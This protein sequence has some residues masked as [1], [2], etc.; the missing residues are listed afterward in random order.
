VS[1]PAATLERAPGAG[2]TAVALLLYGGAFAV[3]SWIFVGAVLA[4]VTSIEMQMIALALVTFL[5]GLVPVALDQARAPRDRHLLL[6]IW[7]LAYLC[8]FTFPLLT[9]YFMG[10][11][12]DGQLHLVNIMPTDIMMGQFAA[13]LGLLCLYAGYSYPIGRMAGSL[14]PRPT[15]E[16]S[17]QTALAI[18]TAMIPLGWFVFFGTRFGLFPAA[19]GSGF[20]GAIGSSVYFGIGLLTII[21]IRYNSQPARMMLWLLIPPT[22]VIGFL[23][24]SKRFALSPLIVMAIAYIVVERRIRMRWVIGGLLAIV[25][26]YPIASVYREFLYS[27]ARLGFVDIITNPTRAVAVLS[28][29][30]GQVSLF[31]YLQRGIVATGTRMDLLG[32]VSV[33]VRD[34]PSVVPYQLGWSLAYI[35]ISFVPRIIW[36]GKPVM[37]IG[38]W[39]TDNFGGGEGIISS[40][41]SSWPGE[42]FFNFGWVGIIVGMFLVGVWF[43]IL[44]EVLFRW[45]VTI[46]GLMASLVVLWASCPTIEMTLLAPFAG[47]LFNTFP[48]FVA[49]I[50]VVLA[51]PTTISSALHVYQ[52]PGSAPADG[53]G[54]EAS[55][56]LHSDAP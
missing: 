48:I 5:V 31:D 25:T 30:L 33:I 7:S 15:R 22:M 51:T 17:H 55:P 42:L 26:L 11:Q 46:P 12:K 8:F 40:T 4:G 50:F 6:T 24:G 20:L 21:R 27:G 2:S 52:P 38:Q 47:I 9:T 16:W 53:G 43:R 23:T 45:D 1:A 19:L 35:P 34:T 39:V 32:I 10:G 29:F 44:H 3:A 36:P 13:L 56:V 37:A 41:G 14:L 54:G 18:A 28:S 49:H